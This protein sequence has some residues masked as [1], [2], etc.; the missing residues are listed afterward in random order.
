MASNASM[1]CKTQFPSIGQTWTNT[2]RLHKLAEHHQI[3]PASTNEND[4]PQELVFK[5]SKVPLNELGVKVSDN[6]LEQ[7]P[8][9]NSS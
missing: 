5:K 1:G 7:T 4:C 3:F 2:A 6:R 8:R 9:S